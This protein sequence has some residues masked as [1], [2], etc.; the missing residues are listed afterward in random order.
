MIRNPGDCLRA[1]LF[2]GRFLIQSL[3][4]HLVPKPIQTPGR[5]SSL[6]KWCENGCCAKAFCQ[7]RVCWFWHAHYHILTIQD[8]YVYVL[9]VS[10]CISIYVSTYKIHIC[11]LVFTQ[12]YVCHLSNNPRSCVTV[13]SLDISKFVLLIKKIMIWGKKAG[14]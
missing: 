3:L 13:M 10:I 1:V 8:Y 11:I 7:K 14:L 5:M 6:Q 9:T 4:N 12:K 2:E